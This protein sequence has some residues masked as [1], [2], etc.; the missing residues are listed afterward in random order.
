MSDGNVTPT[1]PPTSPA[2]DIYKRKRIDKTIGIIGQENGAMECDTSTPEKLSLNSGSSDITTSLEKISKT[3][4]S[5]TTL[6]TGITEAIAIPDSNNYSKLL[7]HAISAHSLLIELGS[8][9]ELGNFEHGAKCA[10]LE[11]N[12]RGQLNNSGRK[13]WL[14]I[15]N[16]PQLFRDHVTSVTQSEDPTN[17]NVTHDGER[18]LA[19]DAKSLLHIMERKRAAASG[20]IRC[21]AARLVLIENIRTLKLPI[22]ELEYKTNSIG[23]EIFRPTCDEMEFGLKCFSRAGRAILTHASDPFVAY[24]TLSMAITCWEGIRAYDHGDNEVSQPKHASKLHTDDVFESFLLLVESASQVA[25]SD[26]RATLPEKKGSIGSPESILHHLCR[27]KDFV[28]SQRLRSVISSGGEPH[29]EEKTKIE[30]ASATNLLTIQRYLPSLARICYKHGNRFARLANYTSAEEA[31]HIALCT[32]DECLA[33]VRKEIEKKKNGKEMKLGRFHQSLQIQE[34]EMLVLSKQ[35]FYVLCRV[36]QSTGKKIEAN[37]CLD[38]I[39]TY[40]DHQQQRDDEIFRDTMNHLEILTTSRH[41]Q[42]FCDASKFALEG[43]REQDKADMEARARLARAK[44]RYGETTERASLIFSKIM[45]MHNLGSS[46]EDE[47]SIDTHF[48]KLVELSILQDS[49]NTSGNLSVQISSAVAANQP[50]LDSIKDTNIFDLTLEV[51]RTTLTR[52]LLLPIETRKKYQDPFGLF[53]DTY[54]KDHE[55][56]F[57][58]SLAHLSTLLTSAADARGGGVEVASETIGYLDQCALDIGTAFV[59]QFTRAHSSKKLLPKDDK[60]DNATLFDCSQVESNGS[61]KL[62]EQSRTQF[63]R[64]VS[65][66]HSLQL[67]ETKCQ[68]IAWCDLLIEIIMLS[69]RY[70]KAIISKEKC[71][72][73]TSGIMAIKAVALSSNVNY[74]AGLKTA[75]EAFKTCGSEVG[76]VV[77]LFYCSVRYELSSDSSDEQKQC[78][79]KYSNTILELDNAISTFLT[80]SKILPSKEFPEDELL[81]SFPIMCNICMENDHENRRPLLL[82]LQQRWADLYI[83]SASVTAALDKQN[84]DR[85]MKRE[86]PGGHALF[87]ILRPYLVN[88]E[89]LLSEALAQNDIKWQAEHCKLMNDTLDLLIKVRG[90]LR[91]QQTEGRKSEIDIYDFPDVSS[92]GE[93]HGIG[94]ETGVVGREMN[95]DQCGNKQDFTLI[96]D[97]SYIQSFVGKYEDCLWT[98]KIIYI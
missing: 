1:T 19:Q 82:Q 46:E 56:Y 98:G 40:I 97:S 81:R 53:I 85:G 74:G 22:P 41:S 24:L 44:A 38:R 15:K 86:P 65:F 28:T 88:F 90:C 25:I 26:V 75:R 72:E 4:H 80:L 57:S 35:S 23:R 37:K 8:F 52:R 68:T 43:P 6:L 2:V 70:N 18:D 47:V 71:D 54:P 60:H 66:Y 94:N 21:I 36:F 69:Q 16:N 93:N 29:A 33:K 73:I 13:M 39:E 7:K 3:V 12:I 59:H 32:T 83:K 76:N 27:L 51:A 14:L 45:S 17:V 55:N 5:I 58:V 96:W 84:K 9:V 10:M 89:Y 61:T 91:P 63:A 64:A 77:T 62:L 50:L 34:Q 87:S 42:E 79:N 20:Y 11:K 31:L 78:I 95:A 48:K 92:M 30:E 67:E 49:L